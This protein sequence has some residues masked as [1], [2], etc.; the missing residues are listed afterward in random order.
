ML[1]LITYYLI[2]KNKLL[3]LVPGNIVHIKISEIDTQ[4]DLFVATSDTEHTSKIY[5]YIYISDTEHA[6]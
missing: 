6:L 2:T 5:I 3:D 1:S 4:L